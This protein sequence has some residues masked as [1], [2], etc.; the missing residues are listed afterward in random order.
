MWQTLLS[1][2]TLTLRANLL[3]DHLKLFQVFFGYGWLTGVDREE[4][5]T[6]E[7]AKHG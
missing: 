4:K 1:Q 7:V 3:P 2:N 5:R 6:L